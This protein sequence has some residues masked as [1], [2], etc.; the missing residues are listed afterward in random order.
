MVLPLDVARLCVDCDI[1]T[2]AASCPVCG[3]NQTVHLAAWMK[4]LGGVALRDSQTPTIIV[5]RDHHA[6]YWSIRQRFDGRAR[7]IL[8]RR[9]GERRCRRMVVPM[10]RRRADQREPL[11]PEELDLWSAYGY[12]LVR[13]VYGRRDLVASKPERSGSAALR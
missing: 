1:L 2:Q 6:V 13:S 4:P 7:V 8:D 5:R 10:E 3:R 11:T 12:R 9:Q